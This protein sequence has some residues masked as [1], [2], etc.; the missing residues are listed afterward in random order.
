MKSVLIIIPILIII[1]VGIVFLQSS[2]ILTLDESQYKKIS[3]MVDSDYKYNTVCELG[4]TPK[5]IA[6]SVIPTIFEIMTGLHNDNKHLI[7]FF[8]TDK[9]LSV[10]D[11]SPDDVFS[12]DYEKNENDLLRRNVDPIFYDMSYWMSTAYKIMEISP[13]IIEIVEYNHTDTDTIYFTRIQS[14]ISK[15]Q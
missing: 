7:K 1:M 4:N 13:E 14:E 6:E 10:G 2:N 5:E 3:K 12:I 9:I 8:E 15:C 11:I